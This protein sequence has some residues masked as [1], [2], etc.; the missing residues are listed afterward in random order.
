MV[1]G[2]EYQT[3]ENKKKHENDKGVETQTNTHKHQANISGVPKEIG[4][5]NYGFCVFLCVLF[6]WFWLL[7]DFVNVSLFAVYLLQLR[8]E[9]ASHNTWENLL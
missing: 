6:V 8:R 1:K 2:F 5:S 7:S 4:R 3:K 9:R